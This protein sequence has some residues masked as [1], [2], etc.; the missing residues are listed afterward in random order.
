SG[1]GAGEFNV[2][3]LDIASDLQGLSIDVLLAKM[4]VRNIRTDSMSLYKGT[5]YM[6]S[7]PKIRI[8]DKVKEIKGHHK[9]DG[10]TEYERELLDS[11]KSC[12]R[13]EV[14]IRNVR[15]TLQDVV[16]DPLRFGSYFDRLEFFKLQGNNDSGVLQVLYKHMNRKFRNE[17]E[18][19]RDRELEALLKERYVE[20]VMYWFNEVKEP[21]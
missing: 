12:T 15:K 18:V 11:G 3:R 17:L 13:F 9:Y 8:Y 20:G 19:Y 4:R 5:I 2:S 7:N 16:D 14:Q 10:V 21:F 6:G 1:V